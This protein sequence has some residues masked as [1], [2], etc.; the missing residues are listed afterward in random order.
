MNPFRFDW[1]RDENN[2][3]GATAVTG[4]AKVVVPAALAVGVGMAGWFG[5]LS[6]KDTK[7][8]PAIQIGDNSPV[9]NGGG[10]QVVGDNATIIHGFSEQMFREA[11]ANKEAALRAELAQANADEQAVLRAQ[12]AEVERQR[13]DLHTA[14]TE[15][16]EANRQLRLRL[17]DFQDQVPRA[18]LEEA[19]QALFEKGDPTLADQ[20]LAEVEDA[21]QDAI[22]VASEAA[23][24]RGKIAEDDIRWHDAANHY[25]RAAQL[26]PTYDT[27]HAASQ[28]FWR[29]GRYPEALRLAGDL[30]AVA[31][32]DRGESDA[33]TSTALNQLALVVQAQGRYAEAEGLFNRALEIDRAT[34]GEEHPDYAIRLNNLAHVVQAQGRYAEAE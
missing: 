31:R 32:R 21:A 25:A 2:R 5:F 27:L 22:H 23:F 17:S 11:L 7:D 9:N 26:N 18:K 33:W 24:E 30:V 10:T 28:L 19:Q 1:W 14:Y 15:T 6:E 16:V 12:L 29:S 13:A 20:L 4:I 34:I 8:T 3:D